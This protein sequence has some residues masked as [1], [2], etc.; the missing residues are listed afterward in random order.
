VSSSLEFARQSMSP[1]GSFLYER[2]RVGR[3]W[4]A[5]LSRLHARFIGMHKCDAS[6]EVNAFDKRDRDCVLRMMAVH[7]TG[8]LRIKISAV[9]K[10]LFQ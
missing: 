5:K 9:V 7:Q 6:G 4:R 10:P 2:E 3:R 1:S 8:Q